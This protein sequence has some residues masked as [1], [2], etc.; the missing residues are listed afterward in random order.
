[1]RRERGFTLVEVLLAAALVIVAMLGAIAMTLTA[2]GQ[3]DRSRAES[4]AT[5]L[6]QQPL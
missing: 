6:A 2:Y 5:A 4:I 1:M 3:L